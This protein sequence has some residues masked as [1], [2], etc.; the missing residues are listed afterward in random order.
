MLLLAINTVLAIIQADNFLNYKDAF[1]SNSR[2]NA[3]I[4]G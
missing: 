4:A 2:I 1:R 3:T